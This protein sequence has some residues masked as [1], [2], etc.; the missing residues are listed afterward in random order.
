MHLTI[1]ETDLGMKRRQRRD[2]ALRGVA[3][4]RS[5]GHKRGLLGVALEVDE[6]CYQALRIPDKARR[7]DDIEINN[8]EN[9]SKNPN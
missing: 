2:E 1:L 6:G 8:L 4:G 7:V 5:L 3:R 9:L